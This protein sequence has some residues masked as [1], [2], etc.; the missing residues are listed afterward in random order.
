MLKMP[1]N[2]LVSHHPIIQFRNCRILHQRRIIRD[3]LWVRNGEILNPRKLFWEE[4]GYADHQIDCQ[5]AIIVPGYIDVQINGGFGY[6]FSSEPELV[7]E[8][9]QKVAQG[10]LSHGVTSFCPTLITSSPDTYRKII[11][12]IHKT[13][14]SNKGAGVLGLHLEGPFISVE[15]RGAHPQ[16]LVHPL[17]G[18]TQDLFDVYSNLDDVAIVTL[19]PEL[20]NAKA[21]VQELVKRGI[22]VSVGHSTANLCIAEE[23]VN[24]GASFI[25]HLFNAM[26]P[27]H[28]RDP[29]IVGLLASNAINRCVYYGVIADGIHTHPAALRIAFQT[30]PDGVVLVTD[31][32]SALGLPPGRHQLG[33]QQLD[34]R[35]NAAYVAGT[36][37]LSGSIATMSS[38]VKFLQGA[39]RCT[40]V[41]A[42]EA[43]TLHPAQLLGITERKGTL[44]YGTDADFLFVDEDLNVKRTYIAGEMVWDSKTGFRNKSS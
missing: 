30:H 11:P 10:I 20:I 19:A 22:T 16:H 4:K 7:S 34:V 39:T 31:A 41:E 33:T 24:A 13:E 21:A 40:T 29:G 32:L 44:D 43:A 5:N 37:T 2:G 35:D 9:I 36:N 42:V 28:H 18:G 26:L 1:S 12:Q 6:D 8:G 3:D 17:S 27:F 23:S 38:C 25:T 15:K 14:G